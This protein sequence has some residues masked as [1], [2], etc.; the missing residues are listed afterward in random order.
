MKKAIAFFLLSIMTLTALQPTVA[1]HFCGDNLRSVAIGKIQKTC[2]ES[3]IKN[4]TKSSPVKAE[5]RIS[6]PMNTCCS[7]YMIELS[8]DNFQTPVQQ[9]IVD[10]QQPTFN[11]VLFPIDIPLKETDSTSS[12]F[13]R[14][15]PPGGLARYCVDR[16]TMI[17]IFRI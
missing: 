7:T 11:P 9:S 4:V 15:F 6:P 5:N 8:T 1:L 3:S 17:C 2:C 16:L 12:S 13:L 10:F 14:R